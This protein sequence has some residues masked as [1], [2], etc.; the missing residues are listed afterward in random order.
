VILSPVFRPGELPP[1]DAVV[2]TIAGAA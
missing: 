1:S 2:D